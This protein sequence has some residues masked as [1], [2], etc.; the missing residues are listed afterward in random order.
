MQCNKNNLQF[1]LFFLVKSDHLSFL[2]DI[3]LNKYNITTIGIDYKK[4]KYNIKYRIK[5]L[6]NLLKHEFCEVYNL[7]PNRRIIDDDITLN[8]GAF[9]KYALYKIDHEFQRLFKNFFD[10]YFYDEVLL[11]R[12]QFY[13]DDLEYLLINKFKMRK[14]Y[15]KKIYINSNKCYNFIIKIKRELSLSNYVVIQFYGSSRLKSFEENLNKMLIN[16]LKSSF[17]ILLIGSKSEVNT[18][19]N[20]CYDKKVINLAGKLNILEAIYLLKESSIFIGIDSS[21]AHFA[22]Y[23]NIPRLLILGGGGYNLMFPK[24]IYDDNSKYNEKVLYYKTNCFGCLWQCQNII[25]GECIK[26]IESNYIINEL[27]KLIKTIG[28]NK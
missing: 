23:F 4:Y 12:K 5:L 2:D 24:I 11:N 19:E 13:S 6:Y 7:N 16:V 18:L 15:L 1:N 9:R 25:Q 21:F 14:I 10:N 20:Y 22:R 3:N 17:K 28:D 8:S 27:K 26:K